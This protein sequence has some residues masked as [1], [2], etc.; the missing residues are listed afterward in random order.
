ML[1]KSFL[2]QHTGKPLK[3]NSFKTKSALDEQIKIFLLSL[4][5][6]FFS[7][8][9]FFFFWGGVLLIVISVR[10]KSNFAIPSHIVVRQFHC[11]PPETSQL[12]V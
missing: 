4:I 9:F 7:S 8:F 12:Q 2:H 3:T 6:H 5:S 1:H 10:K 11:S